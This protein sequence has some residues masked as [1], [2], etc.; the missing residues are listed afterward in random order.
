MAVD[1]FDTGGDSSVL[2]QL[3]DALVSVCTASVGEGE[4]DVAMVGS[5]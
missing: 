1:E 3:D 5:E 4:S 2:Q